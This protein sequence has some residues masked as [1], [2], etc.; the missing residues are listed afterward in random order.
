MAAAT[1]DFI[2]DLEAERGRLH[3][4]HHE[5]GQD[6][7]PAKRLCQECLVFADCRRWSLAQGPELQ[8]VWAGLSVQQRRLVRLRRVA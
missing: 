2:I 6:P 4:G 5:K 3:V 8:G 7:G 1:H